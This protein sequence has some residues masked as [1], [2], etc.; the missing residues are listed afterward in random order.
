MRWLLAGA[1]ALILLVGFSAYRQP[2]LMVE[3]ANQ[4]GMC[5]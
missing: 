3:L 5:R 1:L 4:A 2:D